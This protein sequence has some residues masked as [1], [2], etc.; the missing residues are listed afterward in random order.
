LWE[1]ALLSRSDADKRTAATEGTVS[2]VGSAKKYKEDSLKKW[3]LKDF[4]GGMDRTKHLADAQNVEAKDDK[5]IRAY[6][7]VGSAVENSL[8]KN[9]DSTAQPARHPANSSITQKEP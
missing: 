7:S 6:K 8:K 1:S 5:H 3:Q 4:A 2:T 9:G